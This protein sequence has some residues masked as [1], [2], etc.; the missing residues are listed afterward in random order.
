MA[1]FSDDADDLFDEVDL[2]SMGIEELLPKTQ[3]ASGSNVDSG[4]FSDDAYEKKER[5]IQQQIESYL[6]N[7]VP[8]NTIKANTYALN[9]YHRF[10]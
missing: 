1:D 3:V 2:F 9:S 4:C 7:T 8:P 6:S 10:A 5:T